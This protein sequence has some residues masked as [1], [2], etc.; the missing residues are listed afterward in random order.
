MTDTPRKCY[1]AGLLHTFMTMRM[2]IMWDQA[3]TWKLNFLKAL[4]VGLVSKETHLEFRVTMKPRGK[5][6]DN[7]WL[8]ELRSSPEPFP[9][10]C[11]PCP[12]SLSVATWG[13]SVPGQGYLRI[14]KPQEQTKPINPY[15]CW[16]NTV[17]T[18]LNISKVGVYCN[19]IIWPWP[20]LILNLNSMQSGS[21]SLPNK[22]PGCP[23]LC[24]H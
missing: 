3:V 14:K 9:V 23:L 12:L 11:V 24:Y 5:L 2:E 17:K 4:S 18:G 16:P 8:V 22:L 7:G 13:Q 19:T 15:K 6:A 1:N 21:L 20:T 10:T